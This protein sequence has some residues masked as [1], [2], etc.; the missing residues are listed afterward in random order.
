M[1]GPVQECTGT[2]GTIAVKLLMAVERI[3]GPNFV[4]CGHHVRR[5]SPV[6]PARVGH[7]SD[8]LMLYV[9]EVCYAVG[10]IFFPHGIQ[11]PPGFGIVIDT[12]MVPPTI[13][14]KK[15]GGNEIK[16]TIGG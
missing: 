12:S 16:L 14:S 8:Q 15:Q 7:K 1:T 2:I 9:Y 4:K 3:F 6:I 10:A 5:I 11:N 13:R